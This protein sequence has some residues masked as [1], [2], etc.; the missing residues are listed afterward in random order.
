[1]IFNPG[2]MTM[3]DVL[4]TFNSLYLMC[5]LTF[6]YTFDTESYLVNSAHILLW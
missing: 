2:L 6:K 5:S 1:M 3:F 4:C